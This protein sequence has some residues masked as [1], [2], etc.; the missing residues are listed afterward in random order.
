MLFGRILLDDENWQVCAG[1]LGGIEVTLKWRGLKKRA[2]RGERVFLLDVMDELKRHGVRIEPG[3][4]VVAEALE[5]FADAVFGGDARWRAYFLGM[6]P[7]E[8][9][10][11]H[12]GLPDD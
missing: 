1:L 10:H 5:E 2:V 4:P 12:L 8:T 11:M 7:Q 3:E 9:A 6:T